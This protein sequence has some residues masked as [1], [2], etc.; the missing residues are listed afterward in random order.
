M[1]LVL[2][3]KPLQQPAPISSIIYLSDLMLQ[4]KPIKVPNCMRTPEECRI[5]Y[6]REGQDHQLRTSGRT[7]AAAGK[8]G[9]KTDYCFF[10]A[11]AVLA[12]FALASSF[13]S[14]A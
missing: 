10:F 4:E 1:Q 9:E 6:E 7:L 12:F 14:A 11:A 3:I 5:G 8:R 2:K 13:F